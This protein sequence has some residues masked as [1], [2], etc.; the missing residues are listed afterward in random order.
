M[1]TQAYREILKARHL[2]LALSLNVDQLP[3]EGVKK[4]SSKVYLELL[5]GLLPH[6]D[7]YAIIRPP[8]QVYLELLKLRLESSISEGGVHYEVGSGGRVP[9]W[10]QAAKEMTLDR[11]LVKREV[12]RWDPAVVKTL[13]RIWT[14]LPLLG[15]PIAL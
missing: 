10:D 8:V 9:Y 1:L 11:S 5:K 14:L 7:I 3:A 13:E 15:S 12:L 2:E 4:G 6:M